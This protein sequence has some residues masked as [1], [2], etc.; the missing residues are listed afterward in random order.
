MSTTDEAADSIAAV[1]QDHVD[2][3]N[4][5]LVLAQKEGRC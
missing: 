2:V 4:N 3:C 1:I 5:L